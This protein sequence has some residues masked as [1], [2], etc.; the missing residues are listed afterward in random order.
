MTRGSSERGFVFAALLQKCFVK[1]PCELVPFSG[2]LAFLSTKTLPAFTVLLLEWAC[3]C[4]YWLC[5]A[6]CV[7]M[8]TL[9]E[10]LSGMTGTYTNICSPQRSIDSHFGASFMLLLHY[11]GFCIAECCSPLSSAGCSTQGPSA[12]IWAQTADGLQQSLRTHCQ[13]GL[14]FMV[15]LYGDEQR[16]GW[17]KHTLCFRDESSVV[18]LHGGQ[19]LKFKIRHTKNTLPHFDYIYLFIYFFLLEEAATLSVQGSSSKL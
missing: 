14:C 9:R 1:R 8:V 17:H 10:S 3:P 16:S 5:N 18:L 11:S 19:V 4:W 12:Q 15:L 2:C 7:A 6:T 13:L